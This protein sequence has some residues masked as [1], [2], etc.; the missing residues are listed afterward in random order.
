MTGGAGRQHGSTA[1]A[2][3]ALA[4]TA[5]AF[6]SAWEAS[7]LAGLGGLARRL[8]STAAVRSLVAAWDASWPGRL[9]AAVWSPGRSR[10]VPGDGLALPGLALLAALN[11]WAFNMAPWEAAGYAALALTLVVV[12]ASPEGGLYA[13]LAVI[14]FVSDPAALVLVAVL[15]A[16][17]LTRRLAAADWRLGSVRPLPDLP[18]VLLGLVL[19][20]ATLTSVSLS[21]SLRY[22]VTWVLALGLYFSITATARGTEVLVRAAVAFGLSAALG[23][24]HGLYQVVVNVPVQE[25]WIDSDLFPRV[26]TRIFSFWGNP[27][28]FAL[29]LLLAGPLLAAGV[30]TARD[31]LSKGGVALGVIVSGLALALTLSRAGWVGLAVAILFI[32]LARDRRIILAGFVAAALALVLSPEAVLSRVATLGQFSDPTA[33]H[34]FRIWEASARMARDFWYAGLGLGWRAFAAVYPQYAIEGRVAFHAHSHYLETLLE[35]GILGFA[36]VHWLLAR[37]VFWV[38]ALGPAARRPAGGAVLISAAA[39]ILGSLA[40]GVAEPI[41]YLPRPIL[42]AWAVLGLAAA[43]RE[44]VIRPQAGAAVAD[45]EVGHA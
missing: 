29:H 42:M 14:P 26:G 6:H 22:L 31:R 30:W 13:T 4:A 39:A 24:L 12:L 16:A 8:A 3:S 36:L 44:D 38:L 17:T 7:L 5:L 34:R 19:V 40:F 28:V 37:P 43:A 35:L 27:N 45:A 33:V 32:G 20:V 1:G 9:S 21:G 15:V 2:A 23:G 25:G 11:A 10:P 41:F 18:L